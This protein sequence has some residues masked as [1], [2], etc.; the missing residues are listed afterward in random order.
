MKSLQRLLLCLVALAFIGTACAQQKQKGKVK[1][2]CIGDSITEGWG[3]GDSTYP[4]HLQ[5]LLGEAYEVKNYGIGARTL[6][7]KGDYPYSKEAK[8]QDAQNWEPNIVII[9][10][11][12]NDTKPQNWKYK[13]DFIN[14]YKAFIAKLKSVPSKPKIYICYPIP[15]FKDNFGIRE[16]V[17]KDEMIPMIKSIADETGVKLIDLYTPMLPYGNLVPDGVH[18]NRTGTYYL[19][20]AVYKAIK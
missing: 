6:L 16:S 3:L 14:D 20:E 2:A 7:A 17:L 5:R 15:V 1:V 18:P 4:A 13:D 12:T 19:A 8:F 9:K 11:G 10:L